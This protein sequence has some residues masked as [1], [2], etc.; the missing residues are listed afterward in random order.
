MRVGTLN[1]GT[2]TGKGR[3]LA[4]MMERRRVDILC[5][6]ETRWK[7]SKARSIGGGFKLFY[8]GV[9]GRRNGIG[10]V[11][12]EE[13]VKNVLEVKRVSD[14]VMSMKLEIEGTI[15][16]VV[17]AYAPQVGCGIEEKEEFWR[18]LDEVVESVP[19][20]E[21]VVM[22]ADLNGHVGE[23]NRGDEEVMG[24]YGVKERNVE[25]QMVVDF[26]KRMEMAVVNTYFKKREEHRVTYKSGGRSTQ[27]DYVLCRRC[28]LK[29]IGDCKVVTGESVARQHRMVVCRMTLEIKKRKRVKVEPR[30]KWWKLKKEDCC[31]EF[32]VELRQALGGSEEL[33][34]DWVTTAEVVRETARK[35]LG[36]SS[37]QRKE[38]KETW[39]W[40]EEVQQSIQRKRLAKKKWDSQ[41]DE[42]S[43]Q[44]YKLMRHKAKRE[45]AKAK[46]KVYGELYERLDTKEG[47]KDLYR[48]AR[49]RDRAGK[50]VQQIRV[51]KDRDG[52]MLTSGESVLR[53]WREYF[54][55]LMNEENERERRLDDVGIVDQEVRWISRDEVR[56]AMKRMKSGK[57]VGPDDIPVEVWRCLGEMAV[58]FLT[59]LFNTILE[60]E[61]MPE[62]W[63]RSVLVPIF[64]NKGDVQSC[65]NYR[66]IK[67][68]SHS[69]KLWERV[70]E[71]R[72]R[73]EVMISE[74]QYGFM[75]RKSTTDA[76]FALR[77]L[78][79]KYREGQKE[80][81]CVFVDLEKA[82]DRVPREEVWYCM[83]KS[84][85]AEKYVR[86]VQDM[87]E[88]SVTAVRCAVGVTEGF[89]V[90]VGLHQGSA[91]SPFLFVMVMDRLTDG[92]RQESPWTM[93]FADD[94][95]IC[96]ESR[97]QVEENLERWRYELERRGM[98][99]NRSKT[100]YLCVNGR[101]DG[102]MVR[103]QG[104]E[105]VKVDEF[106]YLGSTV[107]SNGECGKEVKKRVQAGWS[108][109]RRV[110]GVI[111]DR[112]VAAR[113]KGK[114]YKTVVRP[115]MLYGMETVALT[116]RQEAE[117]EVAE[118]RMLRFS[119]GVTRMDRIRNEYIRG[120]AQVGRFGEKAREARLR[121][122]GH[123]WRSDAEYIGKRMLKMEL[124]GKRKRGRPKRRF[125]DAVR[126]D[127]QVV[128]TIEEDA[129]E[130]IRWKRMIRCG[131][132]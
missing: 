65:S 27:V 2:M 98:K 19:K 45:V 3:E 51:M 42:E 86:V 94:I 6:Q 11:L 113:V 44:E 49:Q 111:C 106:K 63:R 14:R 54:E 97:E 102:G 127:M 17:S 88:G 7:G 8:H 28:N 93:M 24:R 99:V 89:K 90:E 71:T 15:L 68:I 118:L 80:L 37:G 57:A 66:G 72:L 64:K 4:D 73:R 74:Q 32:R 76:M 13:Y 125:M 22:G 62:E 79:E 23:G 26:A 36:V 77:M 56:A 25:G 91:L 124:P 100:E 109:W 50:D 67:L 52:S 123:V 119:L 96:S 55:G 85:V 38:D 107:Q 9:D 69:M 121:W 60:S 48:L 41:G 5:V 101:E 132:P 130:R 131:D 92:I 110:S 34:A 39:W 112:R 105:V 16:N 30:I 78:M 120:T 70:V 46:E 29:E 126:E 40:N 115:A 129:E 53:R 103:M 21:R 31:V 1:V 116:K 128:G 47:E 117:L 104:V 35:V 108:G 33:P 114:V 95:V 59:R 58:W 61:R 18:E 84:G 82:Y 43:R 75:P 87:Y 122:F 81:H 20:E 83:R 12:K 10:V